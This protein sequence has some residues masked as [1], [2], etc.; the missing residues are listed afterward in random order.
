VGGERAGHCD[1]CFTGEYPVKGSDG[2]Q[3][4]Y[5]LEATPA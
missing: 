3:G 1:A 4:K 5:A 2:A